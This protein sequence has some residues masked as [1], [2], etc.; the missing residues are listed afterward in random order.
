MKER[1]IR[2]RPIFAP[3][4]EASRRPLDNNEVAVIRHLGI[5]CGA[6]GHVVV[7]YWMRTPA[8][9]L[10]KLGLAEMWHRHLLGVGNT[11]PFYGLTDRGRQLAAAILCPRPKPRRAKSLGATNGE[12]DVSTR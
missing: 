7:P 11:G 9:R 2:P 4:A 5:H 1:A 3:L 6:G 8:A 12:D 10:L